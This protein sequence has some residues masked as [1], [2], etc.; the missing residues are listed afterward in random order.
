MHSFP[1]TQRLFAPITPRAG[2]A[3]AGQSQGAV[4]HLDTEQLQL[5]SQKH[6]TDLNLVVLKETAP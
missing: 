3:A 4:G 5:P 2:R 6:L 1:A